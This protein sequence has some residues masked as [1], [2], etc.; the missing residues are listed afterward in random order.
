[1]ATCFIL[2]DKNPIASFDIH[3]N[4]AVGTAGHVSS[5]TVI[6]YILEQEKGVVP[7]FPYNIR[8]GEESKPVQDK[9]KKSEDFDAST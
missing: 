8:T 3:I 2:H 9:Q 7:P 5:E 6:K 1:M 4:D